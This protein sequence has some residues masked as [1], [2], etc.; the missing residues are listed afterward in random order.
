MTIQ[1]PDSIKTITR[2]GNRAV[3][4]IA[5]LM[6]GYGAT[7]ANPLRR[8][9][10]SSLA[11]SAVTS[12]KIKGVDHQF[13]TLP[14][15]REDIIEVIQNIKQIRFQCFSNE[16][17]VVTLDV[18]GEKEVTAADIKTSADVEVINGDQHLVTITDKKV[19]F[20]MELTVEK[21]VGYVVVE[22]GQKDKLSIG[23]ISV[24][25]I[26]SPVRL[27]NFTVEDI[28]VGQRIDY[29]KVTME[30]VTDGSISPEAALKN[31]AEILIEQLT[32]VTQLPE[33][34]V[35]KVT[36]KASKKA[37]NPSQ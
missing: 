34:E 15:I 30:I 14:G 3:F 1:V 2:D 37:K 18:K 10:L 11:G 13:S 12:V 4:E 7:L 21:G 32:V 23:V 20:S 28:R 9:L 6:P 26:F 31:A 33:V 24:D 25:A 5:P 27:V 17:V 22:Q 19:E 16:P 36:K 29:N 8:I 35:E